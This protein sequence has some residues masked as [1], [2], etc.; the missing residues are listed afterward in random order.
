[1]NSFIRHMSTSSCAGL[2][3]SSDTQRKLE[4]L[5]CEFGLT[6]SRASWTTEGETGTTTVTTAATTNATAT[7][8]TTTNAAL[9][10]LHNTLLKAEKCV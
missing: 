8:T 6:F 4:D 10:Q 3:D 1:M 2:R 7:S 9:G 5:I